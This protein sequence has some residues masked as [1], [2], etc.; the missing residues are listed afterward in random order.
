[1]LRWYSVSE[2]AEEWGKD[3]STILRWIHSGFVVSLGHRLKRDP[4]GHWSIGVH[5]DIR[6]SPKLHSLQQ[7]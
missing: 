4:T 2:F 6:I 7:L 5:E 1:M 3:H